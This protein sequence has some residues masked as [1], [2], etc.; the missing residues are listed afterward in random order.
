MKIYEASCGDNIFA[1]L[2]EMFQKSYR[3]KEKYV[4]DFNGVVLSIDARQCIHDAVS[5]FNKACKG[6]KS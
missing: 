4:V 2:E 3:G 5:D 6:G 1:V